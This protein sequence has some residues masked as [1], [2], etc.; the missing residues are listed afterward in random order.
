MTLSAMGTHVDVGCVCVSWF[1]G[2][3]RQPHTE[4]CRARFQAAMR[5]EAKVKRAE[6][7]REEFAR[8]VRNRTRKREEKEEGREGRRQEEESG[9]GGRGARGSSGR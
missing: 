9:R 4:A 1:K 2:L 7:Q 6:E 5:E 3:S 8:R